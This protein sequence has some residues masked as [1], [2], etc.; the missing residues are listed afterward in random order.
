M[1]MPAV[2]AWSNAPTWAYVN[3]TDAGAKG[4][5]AALLSAFAMGKQVAL[6]VQ[7]VNGFC[8]IIEIN[9]TG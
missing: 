5:I 6:Y 7:P 8:R 4:Y 9:I 3:E 1:G 2:A